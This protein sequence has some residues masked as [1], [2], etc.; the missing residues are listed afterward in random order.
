[1]KRKAFTLIELLVVVAI[2]SIL[3]A[4]LFPV[5]ASAREKARQ[6][7]CTSN[8]RQFLLGIMQYAQDNNETMPMTFKDSASFGPAS[9]KYNTSPDY[10][11]QETGLPQEIMPYIK[12]TQL[13]ECPDDH[14]MRA[15]EAA[16]NTQPGTMTAAEMVGSNYYQ[17]YGTSYKFTNQ[18]YTRLDKA[19]YPNAKKDTGYTAA[20]LCTTANQTGCDYRASGE[21]V[22][23]STFT[24]ASDISP[25][26]GD[27]YT[28]VT[29]S[30]FTRP[31]DTR[32]VGD[33][34]KVFADAPTTSAGT[35]PFHPTGTSIGYV[36]GH[37]KF[38]VSK[39]TTYNSGCDG[40]DWAW[41]HAGSCNL[42]G[43]QRDA[44]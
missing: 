33:W 34:Q 16:A 14:P 27:A 12:S 1:L 36:D 32:C 7:T 3:A 4:I 41:D 29:L 42:R 30:M 15:T 10:A 26:G 23:G 40:I 37:V 24:S 20:T 22:S 18:N 39:G 28:L 6:I 5:F 21:T 17:I 43:L 2:I 31:S 35:F 25:A 9:A 8:M 38:L 44:D 13:F 19:E 11:G